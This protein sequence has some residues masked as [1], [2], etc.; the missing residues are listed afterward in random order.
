MS[1]CVHLH[2]VL[3]CVS[4]EPSG[5]AVRRLLSPGLCLCN[6]TWMDNLDEFKEKQ[7]HS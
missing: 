5:A 7:P 6:V 2:S 3:G 4:R 1:L